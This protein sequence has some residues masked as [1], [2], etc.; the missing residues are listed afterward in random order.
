MRKKFILL[1]LVIVFIIGIGIDLWLFVV[2]YIIYLNV[3][4][5]KLICFGFGLMFIG[6]GIVIY[7]Y[8][9]FV[10][11]FIDY[12]IFIIWDF[13]KRMILFLRIL[14]YVF[15]LVLVIICKGFIGIGMFLIVCLG[16][17]I[18]YFFM[19]FVEWCFLKM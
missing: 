2:N 7:F 5:S 8:M 1:G 10:L 19:F 9:K 16:G 6:F 15:F 4:L 3:L 18:F 12:L 13:F 11:M 14:V 17:M